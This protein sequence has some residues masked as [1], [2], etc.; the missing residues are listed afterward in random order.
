[1]LP[2][3]K[4]YITPPAYKL[5]KTFEI[6]MMI[7]ISKCR[8]QFTDTERKGDDDAREGKKKQ[9]LRCVRY[10]VDGEALVFLTAIQDIH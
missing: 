7:H 4:T 1:M 2:K 3:P 10:D 8:L 9:N 6:C 5:L